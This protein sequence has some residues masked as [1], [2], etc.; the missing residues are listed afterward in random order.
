MVVQLPSAA[1]WEGNEVATGAVL[2]RIHKPM[3]ETYGRITALRALLVPLRVEYHPFKSPRRFPMAPGSR[4]QRLC[5]RMLNMLTTFSITMDAHHTQSVPLLEPHS[6]E[7]E[8]LIEQLRQ[9]LQAM[10]AMVVGD[11]SLEGAARTVA[12][13]EAHAQHLM[14]RV[15]L[16]DPPGGLSTTDATLGLAFMA[17]LFNVTAVARLLCVSLGEAFCPADA[18]GQQAAA[19]LLR[20]APRWAGDAKLMTLA[21]ELISEALVSTEDEQ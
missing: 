11:V 2:R 4:T 16:S 13:L 17:M 19:T 21:A 8:G 5:R 12:A 7:L 9:A 10:A 3:M 1:G 14:L 18:A 6:A 20:D 15:L